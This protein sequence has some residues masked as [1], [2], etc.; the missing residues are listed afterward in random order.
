[1]V[2]GTDYAHRSA[3][4]YM[5]HHCKGSS[6]LVSGSQICLATG[7]L[8][9]AS[10]W[11]RIQGRMERR[12][13]PQRHSCSDGLWRM[14]RCYSCFG[15][16]GNGRLAESLEHIV[17]NNTSTVMEVRRVHMNWIIP[18]SLYSEIEAMASVNG[19][20]EDPASSPAAT[21]S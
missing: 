3:S 4:D 16:W 12:A 5:T 9:T 1:M 2:A 13:A 7:T 21:C 17:R 8:L 15:G 14:P 10:A 19:K 6:S 20:E 18:D 11:A